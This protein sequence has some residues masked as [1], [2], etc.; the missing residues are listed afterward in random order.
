MKKLI[1]VF[2]TLC[3]AVSLLPAKEYSYLDPPAISVMDFEVN[4]EEPLVEGNP[5]SKEYFGQLINHTLVTVL[6]QKNN[7]FGLVIPRFPHFPDLNYADENEEQRG[8]Y[9]TDAEYF[10]PLLKI[11]DKKYVESALKENN[12]TINDLYTKSPDAFNF[13]DLD[14]VILGNV[15]KYEGNKI[16]LNVRV[17]NTY[18]GEELFAYNDFI[19]EDMRGLY[20]VCDLIAHK[21]I[22]DILTNYCSQ[23]IV[24]SIQ[25]VSPNDFQKTEEWQLTQQNIEKGNPYLLF[26]QSK[27]EVDNTAKIINFNDTFKKRINRDQ[28]YFML[29][30]SYV[31]TVY[32]ENKQSV[33]EIPVELAPREIKIVQLKTEHLET[34]TGSITIKNWKPTDA[35]RI[36]IIEME[37]D[38]KYLWEV[39][40]DRLGAAGKPIWKN[41]KEGEFNPDPEQENTGGNEQTESPAQSVWLYNPAKQ[42]LSISRLPLMKYSVRIT[43]LPDNI[44]K[45]DIFGILRISSRAIESSDALDAELRFEKDKVLAIEDFGLKSS[46][47][48]NEFKKTRITIL[49]PDAFELGWVRFTYTEGDRDGGL[50]FLN[51]E[52][53]VVES[54]YTEVE[55][56]DFV[57]IFYEIEGGEPGKERVASFNYPKEEIEAKRDTIVVVELKKPAVS[58]FAIDT[59]EKK[60]KTFGEWLSG[61]FGGKKAEEEK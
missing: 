4:I 16:A 8:P 42:E 21:I 34:V 23:V 46:D 33:Q 45:E 55:W 9:K 10:P 49:I 18:R 7:Q 38:A 22:I 17:L 37:R 12:F 60:K 11:Y 53:L 32:N 14:F 48:G 13:P 29:P 54:S 31:V 30:G 59:G 25:F 40:N 57:S 1:L 43:P 39:G 26:C 28:F 50:Y 52:K 36:D 6:I 27:Q 44:S 24:K 58:S 5:V 20:E 35:Y 61:I 2:F 15:F 56:N 51:Y 3:F 47:V 41:F 19:L